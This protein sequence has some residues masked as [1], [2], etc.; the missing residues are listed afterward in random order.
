MNPQK[1]WD[2]PQPQDEPKSEGGGVGE[3]AG[4]VVSGVGEVVV[5]SVGAVAEGAG[6]CL[7]GCG[8]CS[9]AVL[10]ALFVVGGTARAAIELF[11]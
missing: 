7:E 6:S 11:K 8:S 1:P 9:A 4:E 2:K 10:V 3:F 5:E